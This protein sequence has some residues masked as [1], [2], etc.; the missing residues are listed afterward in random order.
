MITNT[1]RLAELLAAS[2]GP[3][4]RELLTD[5]SITEVRINSDGKLW[6]H[7][8]GQGKI[9]CDLPINPDNTRKAIFAVAYHHGECCNDTKPY[10]GAEIPGTGERFQ[11]VLPPLVKSPTIAIRKKAVRIFT[12]QDLR[13][14]GVI[15]HEQQQYLQ[16]AVLARQNILV[17]G[18]T[19]TGKTTFANALLQVITDTTD[20]LV[21][22]ED[23]QELQCKANDIEYLRTKDGVASLRDLLKTTL[24]LSPDRIVIGEVRGPEALDLLKAWN[25]GH[26]GGVSTIHA[27]SA[28]QGLSRLEQLISEAGVIPSKDMISEAVNVLVY[29]EKQAN[30]RIVKE[31]FEVKGVSNG[32]Y[33]LNNIK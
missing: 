18:G 7:K 24:R 31:I 28:A 12:L 15:S 26:S 9:H 32:Q 5:P 30:K 17:I 23:T 16:N 11:G 1:D 3:K 8:L 2:L 6:Y 10:V 25:T 27:S 33:S 22:I 21:I 29:L 14:K 4:V 13:E 20:R 19:D